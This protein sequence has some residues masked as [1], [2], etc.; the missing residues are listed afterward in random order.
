MAGDDALERIAAAIADG[1]PVDWDAA[2]G[3]AS[4]DEERGA[5]LAL[6]EAAGIVAGGP[7]TSTPPDRSGSSLTRN[8]ANTSRQSPPAS[9]AATCW[10]H[11][12]LR[13]S[14]GSGTFGEVYVAWDSRLDREVAL[15]LLHAADP[16]SPASSIIAEG[17]LLAR[18][19]HPNVV[20]VFGADRLD[21]RVGIWMELI[22]G[23]TLAD[24][25]REHGPLGAAEATVI[26][27]DL[28]CALAAVHASGLLHRDVKA[29]NVMR[30]AGGRVVL[31]DFGAGRENDATPG[32]RELAGTPAYL[33][34]E[35]LRG[36]P[37][38]V[39]SDIYSLGV[40][41]YFLVTGSYPVTAAT[42]TGIAHAHVNRERRRLVDL[43]RDLPDAF[44]RVVERAISVDPGDRYD[45]A[46]TLQS[47]LAGTLAPAALPVDRPMDAPIAESV[48]DAS[49]G[50]KSGQK[51]RLSTVGAAVGA[52]LLVTVTAASWLFAPASPVL[53]LAARDW[54]LVGAFENRTGDRTFEGIVEYALQHELA[55]SPFLNVVPRERAEDTLRMM[56]KPVHQVLDAAVGREVCLRD[57]AIRALITG[58]LEKSGTSYSLNADVIDPREGQLVGAVAEKAR[59]QKDVAR[60]AARLSLRLRA[61][62]GE[63]REGI[64]A[65]ERA[66][67]KGTTPSLEA[68]KLYSEAVRAGSLGNWL[69]AS[70]FARSAIEEDAAFASAHAWL[71]R[72]LLFNLHVDEAIRE[73]D[74]AEQLASTSTTRE[75]LYIAAL[76]H[77]MRADLLGSQR[78]RAIV[79]GLKPPGNGEI[80]RHNAEAASA[81]EAL[82]RLYP[83][84]YLSAQDLAGLYDRMGRSEDGLR[85]AETVARLRPTN[86]AANYSVAYRL[87]SSG[88]RLAEAAPFLARAR[89]LM[90]SDVRPDQ[91][92]WLQSEAVFEDWV[93][94]DVPAMLARLE[95]LRQSGDRRFADDAKPFYLA[96]GCLRRAETLEQPRPE[97]T[98]ET[99]GTGN[100]LFD[101]ALVACHRGDLE[102]ARKFAHQLPPPPTPATFRLQR[103]AV[104]PQSIHAWLYVRLGLLA[105][106]QHIVRSWE[107]LGLTNSPGYSWATGEVA[108]ARG[109]VDAAIRELRYAVQKLVLPYSIMAAESLADA[110]ERS[111]RKDEACDLLEQ[112]TRDRARFFYGPRVMQSWVRARGHLAQLCERSGRTREADQL[113]AELRA[114]LRY[115][116]PDFLITLPAVGETLRRSA[117]ASRTGMHRPRSSLAPV[118]GRR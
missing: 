82:R 87:V 108:L 11:L 81:Y 19:R 53:P 35:V 37:A 57:G 5:I 30:E 72:S 105:D 44:V 23:R 85:M 104:A 17:R 65:S 86:F 100:E 114:L 66:F 7:C 40:L 26:G 94:G 67:E 117:S 103:P 48:P 14:I 6:R 8:D 90:P 32:G 88:G 27:A 92:S 76:G 39:R 91:A 116:D 25:V 71:A 56:H 101:R 20:T 51:H 98:T 38:S 79:Q 113:R 64:R 43:R 46:G 45:S 75:R 95:Q 77:S 1:S 15:K 109:D 69:E 36:G 115:A 62:L 107:S 28:C 34:P 70:Q 89:M 96:L 80:Q 111:G 60:A 110:F 52:I 42:V 59:T 16:A 84:D 97:G 58:R 50:H 73:I 102:S 106:A 12:H 33:A 54:V 2:E 78:N 74:R 55:H 99:S 63:R 13:K 83:D 24:I 118:S 3:S 112:A 10:G 41:L 21:G 61:M 9:G 18:V 47:E 4:T 31:M 22:E 29:Q 68:L 49:R 93:N